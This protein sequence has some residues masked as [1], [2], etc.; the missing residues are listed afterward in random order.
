MTGSHIPF[1]HMLKDTHCHIWLIRISHRPHR[2]P[3]KRHCRTRNASTQ[4]SPEC[5]IH[6]RRGERIEEGHRRNPYAAEGEEDPFFRLITRFAID[7]ENTYLRWLYET[8]AFLQENEFPNK[9]RSS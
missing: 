4:L 7:F 2:E 8:L 3:E 9:E 6:S 5:T 1:N